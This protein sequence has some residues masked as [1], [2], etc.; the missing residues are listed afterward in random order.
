MNIS[1]YSNNQVSS[2]KKKISVALDPWMHSN[3]IQLKEVLIF[4]AVKKQEQNMKNDSNYNYIGEVYSDLFLV[5]YNS[6]VFSNN[7]SDVE[8]FIVDLDKNNLGECSALA[9]SIDNGKFLT[10]VAV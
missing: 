7:D 3:A 8:T 2:R 1:K 5:D 9:N 4:R 6:A 10:R